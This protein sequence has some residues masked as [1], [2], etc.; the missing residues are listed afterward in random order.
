LR[1]VPARIVL[2]GAT[3]YTGR[4]TAERLVALGER[5]LLAGRSE[6]KLASL[7]GDLGDLEW[8]RADVFRRNSVFDL[9]SEGDVLL[10]TVGPFAKWGEPAVG[11]TIAARGTYLD[12][13]GEPAFIRRVFEEWGP[14]AARGGARLLTAMGY[15]FVPGALA[16][17]LALEDAGEAAVRV[18]VGYYALG[19]RPDSLSAGTKASMVGAS[20]NQNFAFRDGRVQVV[21]P[22]ERVRDFRVKDKRRPAVSIGGAEHFTLPGAYPR[23]REVNVYIGWFPAL[24]RPMQAATAVSSTVARLPGMRGAMQFAGERLVG[25]TG[26]PEAGTTP[27]GLA[28]IV[29]EAYDA[30]GLPLAEVHLTGR[31]PYAFT[32]SFLAWAAKRALDPGVSGSGPL[33]P[34]E[35]FGLPA[36]VEGCEFAGLARV[37]EPAG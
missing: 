13:T 31:D 8:Q 37:E 21:R 4:L 34:V 17:A 15:D 11:A 35:A 28:W 36:L 12:S 2:F 5:P 14:S 22:A 10:S 32:A 23:L 6:E 26:S 9:V 30:S 18:D 7:A 29:G 16:G 1:L 20:L 3:G 25:L 27:G 19:G 33:G 24:A